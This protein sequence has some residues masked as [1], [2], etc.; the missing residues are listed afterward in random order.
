MGKEK[1]I[2]ICNIVALIL[3]LSFPLRL[4]RDWFVYNTTLNSAPFWVWIA[5][6]AVLH[7]IPAAILFLIGQFLKIVR[8]KKQDTDTDEIRSNKE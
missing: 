8:N 7:L 4:V 1:L 2:K 5:A 3:T 6:N